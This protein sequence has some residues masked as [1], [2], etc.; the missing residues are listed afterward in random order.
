MI[1]FSFGPEPLCPSA[2][3]P[4]RQSRGQTYSQSSSRPLW[5]PEARGFY[6]K[7][8]GACNRSHLSEVGL[9]SARQTR[10]TDRKCR[11]R[12]RV[13]GR[14]FGME[15]LADGCMI[16]GDCPAW[17]CGNAFLLESWAAGSNA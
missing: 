12:R 16:P 7:R 8:I 3:A 9:A 2:P 15:L 1:E 14:W 6:R 17:S 13:A 11:F 5:R 10:S 4:A